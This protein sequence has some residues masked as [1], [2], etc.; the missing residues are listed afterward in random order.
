MNK[1]HRETIKF[2]KETACIILDGDDDNYKII[3]NEIIST[4]RWTINYRLIIKR[5]S[6]GKFFKSTYRVGATESQDESA[7]EY[8]DEVT[9]TEVFPVEKTYISYE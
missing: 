7:W 8:D 4:G 2:D 6:D 1:T 5:L 3:E 9:F